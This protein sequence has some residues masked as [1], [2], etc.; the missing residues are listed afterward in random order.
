MFSQT[1]DGYCPQCLTE[2]KKSVMLTN[3][4]DFWECPV[5]RLQCATTGD[6]ILNILKVRG[7]GRLKDIKATD[8]IQGFL[9]SPGRVTEDDVLRFG[10]E[11]DLKD[12]LQNEVRPSAVI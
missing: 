4:M 5:C 9:L 12:F 2:G 1:S 8:Y 3:S 11:Q 6:Q 7:N 10:N